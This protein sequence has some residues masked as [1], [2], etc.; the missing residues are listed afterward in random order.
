M[1]Y[2]IIKNG[3][4]IGTK[5]DSYELKNSERFGLFTLA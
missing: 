2:N 3:S 1:M 5:G 4:K